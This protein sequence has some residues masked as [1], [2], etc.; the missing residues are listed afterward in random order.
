MKTKKDMSNGKISL[1][2]IIFMIFSGIKDFIREHSGQV[3]TSHD[4][5]GRSLLHLAAS[6]G[7]MTDL[8]YLLQCGVDMDLQEESSGNSPLHVATMGKSGL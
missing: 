5:E 1:K 6:T 8:R 7:N 2:N 4:S 3:T